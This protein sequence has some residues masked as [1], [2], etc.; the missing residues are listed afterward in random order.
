VNGSYEFIVGARSYWRSSHNSSF[1]SGCIF[2][3]KL[4][5]R[6]PINDRG[7]LSRRDNKGGCECEGKELVEERWTEV[8]WLQ[9]E[10]EEVSS[11]FVGAVKQL[12]CCD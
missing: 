10:I 4:E 2:G 3:A 6:K 9:I 5:D 12:K 1:S 8:L 11:H 7:K